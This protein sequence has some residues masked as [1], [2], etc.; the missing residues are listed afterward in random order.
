V[1]ALADDVVQDVPPQRTVGRDRCRH[2]VGQ[3]RRLEP[4]ELARRV[5]AG[6]VD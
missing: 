3:D 4:P 5:E 2:I 6:L 1:G